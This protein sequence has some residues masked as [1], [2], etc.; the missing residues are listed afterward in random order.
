MAE[1]ALSCPTATAGRPLNTDAPSAAIFAPFATKEEDGAYHLTLAVEGIGCAGCIQK[2]ESALAKEP[3]IR[4]ARV[5]FSTQRLN[6]AWEGAPERANDF[7]ARVQGLGYKVRPFEAGRGKKDAEAEAKSLLLAMAVAGFANGNIMLLSVALWST[8]IQEMGMVTREL[9][10]WISALIAIPTVLYSG[11]TFFRS[12][13]SVL[14]KGQ[15]N[16][17]VPISV[18]IILTTLMSLF[19]TITKQEHAYFDSVVMLMFFLLIGRYLDFRAR[20]HARSAASDLLSLMAGTATVIEADGSPRTV[21][22]RDL[23][24]GMTI[25]VAMGER[26][27]AD[28][29]VEEGSSSLDTS[30]ITGESLPQPITV[31]ALAQSG[32]LNL[33]APLRLKIARAAENSLLADIVRLMEKAEQGQ[34]LYVRLADRAA[35]LYTPVVHLLA[36]ITFIGWMVLSSIGWQDSLMIAV[37]VL[38]ITCPCAIGLAVPVVQVLATSLLM[39]RGIL[40][41]TGDAFERL[42][43]IDTLLLDKTGTLTVGHPELAEADTVDPAK[44]RLAASLACQSRHP[45]SRAIAS[46]CKQP[47]LALP[48]TEHPGQGLEAVLEGKRIRLG[49]RKWCDVPA[50]TDTTPRLELWLSVSGE[51]PYAFTFTDPLR[52]DTKETLARLKGM[53]IKLIMLSGDRK[54]TVAK[55]AT[56]LGLDEAIGEMTPQ[57]KFARLEQLR[58]NGRKVGMVGDGLNDAPTLAGADVSLSPATAIDMAQNAAD[59]VFLSDHLA[60]VAKAVEIARATQTLVRENFAISIV[61][62]VVAIP[63]AM[64]G[65]ITPMLAALA[66]SGSSLLVIGNAFRLKR[67]I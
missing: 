58:A 43:G 57:E 48:I 15:T 63:F 33:D 46:A 54:E 55:V 61:Y 21:A 11:R 37:A 64:A 53:G 3:D 52:S 32:M 29:I 66:M 22:I 16:M 27:P 38:I 30:L 17:D 24:E 12:A 5:N 45:L 14:R 8:T 41:K 31:G 13:L 7:A 26:I 40:V 50:D 25:S 36:L 18:G 65:Y 60:P 1:P 59:I 39:K 67:I 44:L 56:E 19:Q 49:S 2:I 23:R 42:A 20:Q 9:F 10:H 34:A 4:L 35:R 6:L 28:A 51:A 47:L 62:N